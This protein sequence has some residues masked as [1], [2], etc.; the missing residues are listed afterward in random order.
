MKEQDLDTGVF[1]NKCELFLGGEDG[2]K[3][4]FGRPVVADP[5]GSKILFPNIARIRDMS[6]SATVHVDVIAVFTIGDSE[7]ERVV[8]Q[9][10]ARTVPIMLM[11]D[12]CVLNGLTSPFGTSLANAR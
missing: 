5:S 8:L 12:L 11:S 9:D 2:S 3:V 4:Y 1:A 7:P 10:L 6:Y